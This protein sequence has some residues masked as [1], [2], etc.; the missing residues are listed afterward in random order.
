[1][2]DRKE[3]INIIDMNIH[4]SQRINEGVLGSIGDF[5]GNLLNPGGIFTGIGAGVN[6]DRVRAAG[7]ASAWILFKAMAGPGTD[8]RAIDQVFA[9]T[10]GDPVKIAE[11]ARQFDMLIQTLIDERDGIGGAFKKIGIGAL[12][13]SLLGVGAGF[14]GSKL[15]QHVVNKEADKFI[16]NELPG[17]FNGIVAGLVSAD[18]KQRAIQRVAQSQINMFADM[19]EDFGVDPAKFLAGV[20]ANAGTALSTEDAK[21]YAGAISS[22]SGGGLLNFSKMSKKQKTQLALAAGLP[23]YLKQNPK[24]KQAFDKM[25]TTAQDSMNFILAGDTA[26]GAMEFAKYGGLIG[27]LFGLF[28]VVTGWMTNYLYD[29]DLATWLEDDGMDQYA[30]MVRS[31][32]GGSRLSAGKIM[33]KQGELKSIIREEMIKSKA[34]KGPVMHSRVVESNTILTT[35]SAL[36]KILEEQYIASKAG[37]RQ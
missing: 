31:A 19:G 34:P 20:A 16:Q 27:G 15:T 17:M 6:E 26:A 25:G 2:M 21:V 5:F 22:L 36:K 23:T 8:E 1:M 11:L 30:A 24:V 7:G 35:K 18:P 13:G 4:S 29:D 9:S 32:L 12:R 37:H 28:D 3:I 10:G 33:I 14:A